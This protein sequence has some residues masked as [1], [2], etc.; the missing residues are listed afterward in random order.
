M[1]YTGVTHWSSVWTRSVGGSPWS[2]RWEWAVWSL[3]SIGGCC[4]G[5]A[6]RSGALARWAHLNPDWCSPAGGGRGREG[7]QHSVF[8]LLQNGNEALTL[9]S[10]AKCVDAHCFLFTDDSTRSYEQ[11][12]TP[13]DILYVISHFLRSSRVVSH[14]LHFMSKSGDFHHPTFAVTWQNQ[15]HGQRLLSASQDTQ[16]QSRGEKGLVWP[17]QPSPCVE[18]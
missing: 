8:S 17:P 15:D 9:N 13:Q 12:A 11:H 18:L 6:R 16:T 4:C 10:G 5:R 3:R 14:H 7:H 1:T 2:G